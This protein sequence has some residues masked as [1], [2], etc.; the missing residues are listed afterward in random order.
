MEARASSSS[1]GRLDI[2]RVARY[3]RSRECARRSRTPPSTPEPRH[4]RRISGED[5]ATYVEGQVAISAG[6]RWT[7]STAFGTQVVSSAFDYSNWNV[8]AAYAFIDA[9][10][11]DVRYH[12]TDERAFGEIYQ[13]RL[14]ASLRAA[15]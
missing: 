3:I 1:C 4:P 15:F 11:L 13:G 2:G 5:E 6:P 14:V 12:T 8:G 10:A 7:V 9:L